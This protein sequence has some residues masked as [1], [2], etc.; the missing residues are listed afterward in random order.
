MLFLSLPLLLFLSSYSSHDSLTHF[1]D[2]YHVLLRL[3]HS[4]FTRMTFSLFFS[5]YVHVSY[6][7]VLLSRIKFLHVITNPSP[8]Q[9]SIRAKSEQIKSNNDRRD[10]Q[11]LSSDEICNT[12]RH[13]SFPLPPAVRATFPHFART[14]PHLELI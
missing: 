12:S 6:P 1:L 2:S 7:K 8:S 4:Y 13:H 14:K 11:P 10:V 9:I 3:H 5:T